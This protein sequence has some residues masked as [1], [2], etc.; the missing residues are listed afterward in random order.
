MTTTL[1]SAKM[2]ALADWPEGGKFTFHDDPGEH[3]P[4]YVVMPDGAMLEL[5]HHA[6]RGVDIAR[7]KFIVA[8]CNRALNWK[9]SD[10][11]KKQISEIE[12]NSRNAMLNAH[13]IVAGSEANATG[14]DPIAFYR[15]MGDEQ[16]YS[17]KHV[18][19]ILELH[20]SKRAANSA[21]HE[22]QVRDSDLRD[23]WRKAGGAFYGP[24]IET[25]SMP[26]E[27]LLPFLRS[28][29]TGAKS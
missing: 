7:A 22:P 20:L 25:G 1:S 11:T 8:A 26:E 29:Y 6:G 18:A 21:G 2:L 5:N 13:N 9:I 17:G 15:S 24:H 3:D 12:A 27:K 4:C 14:D 23:M 16:V 19:N 28:L 10:D